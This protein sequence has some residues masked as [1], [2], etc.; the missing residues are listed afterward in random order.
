MRPELEQ[1]AKVEQYLNNQMGATDRAQFEQEIASNPALKAMVADQRA[2]LKGVDRIALRQDVTMAARSYHGRRNS[3]RRGIGGVVVAGLI[4]LLLLQWHPHETGTKQANAALQYNGT[5]LPALNEAGK[6][7]WATA[8]S[9]IAAQQFTIHADRDT[10][11]ETQSGMVCSVPANAFINANGKAVT[12]TVQLYIKEATDPL[13]IIKAG[14]STRSGDRLLETGGMFFLDARQGNDILKIDTAKRIYAQLPVSSPK[15][16]MQLFSGK[17]M[18]DGSIDWVNPQSLVHELVDVDILTLNFYPPDYLT[19]LRENG[20]MINRKA[21]TDSVYYSLAAVFDKSSAWSIARP[22]DSRS[23]D[24][25]DGPGKDTSSY[26]DLHCGI[27]PAK[28]KTIWSAKYQH[29]LLATRAF[30]QRLAVIHWFMEPDLLDLYVNNLDKNLYEVDAMAAAK[31][32]N[33]EVKQTFLRF[34]TLRDGKVKKGNKQ[35]DK[36]REYYNLKTKILTEAIVA[37]QQKMA[38]EKKRIDNEAYTKRSN[39]AFSAVDRL[40]ANFNEEL[41]INIKSAYQQ[42]GYPEPPA[43][44]TTKPAFTNTALITNTGWCNV[45]AYVTVATTNRTTMSYTDRQTGKKAVIDYQPIAVSI[46]DATKYD[47]LLVYLL[48]DQLNSFMQMKQDAG[49]YTEKLNGLM[50]YDLVCIGINR[51]QQSLC[52]L[53]NVTAK[54][55]D[56]LQLQVKSASEVAAVLN[57]LRASQSSAVSNE[58]GFAI[59]SV[60]DEQRRVQQRRWEDLFRNL[61]HAF[62]HCF[63]DPDSARLSEENAIGEANYNPGADDYR[64]K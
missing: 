16:G 49:R 11:I 36:L 3:I 47:R 4:A 33:P 37:T 46:A 52:L 10:I 29:T 21:F 35:F 42:L 9:M 43:T 41:N 17:R 44:A 14:L 7:E 24:S 34:A 45:D 32:T 62:F 28:I 26:T 56:G 64:P 1:M 59:W 51:R 58:I 38:Q 30:E 18:A 54:S 55:Y 2:I 60:Q 27:N 31:T 20:F 8:D 6:P 48:P 15:P 39:H 19:R 12:G 23:K 57:K 61:R 40:A 50:R 22:K 5:A 25:V 53:N 13:T 63:E